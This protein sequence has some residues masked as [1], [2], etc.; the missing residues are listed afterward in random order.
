MNSA[1][2]P[3]V[4]CSSSNC[5]KR[6]MVGGGK[7]LK[8]I[9]GSLVLVKGF[10]WSLLSLVII[11][12]KRTSF[13]SW[14]Q[15]LWNCVS[16]AGTGL[17]SLL[18]YL[19]SCRGL[20]IAS[21]RLE[22][23]SLS[24]CRAREQIQ[25]LKK[26][27]ANFFSSVW[28][29]SYSPGNHDPRMKITDRHSIS[30]AKKNENSLHRMNSTLQFSCLLQRAVFSAPNTQRHLRAGRKLLGCLADD[31]GPA[32]SRQGPC[33]LWQLATALLWV[34]HLC[35]WGHEWELFQLSSSQTAPRAFEKNGSKPRASLH[36][37][38]THSWHEENDNHLTVFI[39]LKWFHW[40]DYP[41]FWNI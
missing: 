36:E 17:V 9:W 25:E 12:T 10:G 11:L 40:K 30:G 14:A 5:W 24:V 18:S 20:G 1:F 35:I 15:L 39:K 26:H 22:P 38:P 41:L 34:H 19:C 28:P 23:G 37:V 31:A 21:G 13:S 16:E 3:L 6:K 33:L 27:T 7:W 4:L 32:Q 2:I 8:V 29:F